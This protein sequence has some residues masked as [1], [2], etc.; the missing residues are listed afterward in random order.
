MQW[1]MEVFVPVEGSRGTGP[2]ATIEIA[3]FDFSPKVV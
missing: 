1:E 3:F 2:C